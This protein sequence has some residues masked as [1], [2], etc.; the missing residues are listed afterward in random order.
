MTHYELLQVQPDASTEVIEASWRVLMKKHH[1]DKNKGN[2]ELAKK[3]NQAHDVLANPEK[4][5]AY[6][7]S[8]NGA[9]QMPDDSRQSGETL[10]QW[11]YRMAQERARGQGFPPN[12]RRRKGA[13]PSAYPDPPRRSF[14]E[15]QVTPEEMLQPE[16]KDLIKTLMENLAQAGQ[17]SLHD[18][19]VR[20]NEAAFRTIQEDPVLSVL[21]GIGR[22][23]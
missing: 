19:L 21:F 12:G 11:Q 22:N 8:L 1:P 14:S 7:Y 5:A 4:R 20:L 15:D 17:L 3:L 23:R 16:E 6:D 9:Y 10:G 18:A 13:Y 2:A